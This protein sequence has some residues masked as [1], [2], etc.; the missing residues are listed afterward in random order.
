MDSWTGQEVGHQC[1]FNFGVFG[2]HYFRRSG[3]DH[4]RPLCSGF[5]TEIM[6]N[7]VTGHLKLAYGHIIIQVYV[8][9]DGNETH[10]TLL[11]F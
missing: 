2:I 3:L 5:V 7:H 11:T 6:A 8:I 4:G 10:G 1:L 9:K